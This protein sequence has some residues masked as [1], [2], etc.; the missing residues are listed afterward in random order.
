MNFVQEVAN[1]EAQLVDVRS[2]QEFKSGHAEGALH[3]P[4]N[5]IEAGETDGLEETMPVYVYCASGGRSG[6][7]QSYLKRAGYDVQNIGG[8]SNWAA[9][10][11]K[12][13]K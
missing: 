10:G 11:G 7:A 6:M 2:K 1:N 3:L 9:A 4:L 12:V 5:R 8:L 13:V